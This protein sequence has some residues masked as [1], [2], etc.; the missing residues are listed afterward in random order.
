MS[1]IWI[2]AGVVGDGDG[3]GDRVG[4]E[5]AVARDDRGV[6]ATSG[7][8]LAPV[9]VAALMSQIRVSGYRGDCSPP[10]EDEVGGEGAA[11]PTAG[12]GAARQRKHHLGHEWLA[13]GGRGRMGRSWRETEEGTRA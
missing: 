1:E 4:A 5:R 10:V 13:G 9:V 11:G 2:R 12:G 3:G 8:G 7:G 6:A